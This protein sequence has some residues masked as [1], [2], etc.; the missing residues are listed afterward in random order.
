MFR[1]IKRIAALACVVALV[2][3]GGVIADSARLREDILRLHVVAAS[4][5]EEDQAVKASP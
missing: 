3:L 1:H 4:D 5:S 2:W